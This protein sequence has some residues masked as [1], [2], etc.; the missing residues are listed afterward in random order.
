M[1]L[2]NI[3]KQMNKCQELLIKWHL[4][5]KM[6]FLNWRDCSAIRLCVL[7]KWGNLNFHLLGFDFVTL[8]E[9]VI[10]CKLEHGLQFFQ[11]SILQHWLSLTTICYVV[12][13]ILALI[14][15]I[16][17]MGFLEDFC[18]EVS[19]GVDA[20]WLLGALHL[21]GKHRNMRPKLTFIQTEMYIILLR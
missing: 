5:Q 3:I 8:W 4:K 1:N 6:W 18:H 7:E 14:T 17:M 2:L 10:F 13:Y 16:Q 12:I 9:Q 15:C 11:T 19:L 21:A 20:S